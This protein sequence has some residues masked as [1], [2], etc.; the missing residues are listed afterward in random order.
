VVWAYTT[1]DTE[2]GGAGLTGV[3]APVLRRALKGKM[4]AKTM[5]TT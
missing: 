4:I 1:A 3:R 2:R 5:L